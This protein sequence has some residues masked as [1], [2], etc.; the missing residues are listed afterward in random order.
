M[1]CSVADDTDA[2]DDDQGTLV[3]MQ[4]AY[5]A[6]PVVLCL[7][8]PFTMGQPPPRLTIAHRCGP[9]VRK[10]IENRPRPS[11]AGRWDVLTTKLTLALRLPHGQ[12]QGG[13]SALSVRAHQLVKALPRQWPATVVALKP[14]PGRTHEPLSHAD[15]R[16]RR[17]REQGVLRTDPGSLAGTQQLS[18]DPVSQRP[19]PNWPPTHLGPTRPKGSHT[20]LPCL[21]AVTFHMATYEGWP[22]W[23]SGSRFLA[24]QHRATTLP[25]RL[26]PASQGP[27]RH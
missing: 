19:R 10:A 24:A 6:Q 2:V 11:R 13:G 15:S 5:L 23:A 1:E 27:R 3:E 12:R 9:R 21:R 16:R 7:E 8:N 20:Y 22:R 26:A 18:T 14:Q 17:D 4:A 25:P